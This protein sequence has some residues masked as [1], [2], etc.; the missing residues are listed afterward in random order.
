M[1]I[2]SWFVL[3]A[4]GVFLLAAAAGFLE[5]DTPGELASAYLFLGLANVC[6]AVL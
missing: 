5:Q 1:K 3:V 2:S 6:F 4:A